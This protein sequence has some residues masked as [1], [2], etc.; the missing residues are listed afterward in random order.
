MLVSTSFYFLRR[1]LPGSLDINRKA[2]N[3]DT[4]L[5]HVIPLEVR[6]LVWTRLRSEIGSDAIPD[7][8]R[9]LWLI[10]VLSLIT[11]F[12]F[13]YAAFHAPGGLNVLS[14]LNLLFGL[15]VA[16]FVG[17]TGVL[18]T[19]P[20]KLRFRRGYESAGD[21]ANYLSLRSP[22]AFKRKGTGWTR[23]QVASVVREIIIDQVGIKD[24]TDDS[25]FVHD[26]HL[27]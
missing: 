20:Y 11:V 17:C 14:E 18:V 25:H 10:C 13:N 19:R 21:L 5:E 4:R 3:P 27:D 12:A 22:Q 7:L 23:E 8:A 15:S 9:P 6:R 26:M 24:F 2:F 16:V 1:K